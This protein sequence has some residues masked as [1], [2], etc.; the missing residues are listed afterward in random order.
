MVN[1]KKVVSQ[2]QGIEHSQLTKAILIMCLVAICVYWL[3]KVN[4]PP[5][6]EGYYY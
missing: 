6:D 1:G 3:S 4:P 5:L 2:Q